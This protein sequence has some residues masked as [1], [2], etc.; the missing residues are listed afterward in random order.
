MLTTTAAKVIES[1]ITTITTVINGDRYTGIVS[2]DD[3]FAHLTMNR[4]QWTEYA[5]TLGGAH[6][7]I[8]YVK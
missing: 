6:T 5:I 4:G 2:V 8:Q 1:G 7:P 3:G